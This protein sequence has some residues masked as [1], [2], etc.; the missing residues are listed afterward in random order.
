MMWLNEVAKSPP[1]TLGLVKIKINH[2]TFK[3]IH[4]WPSN[5]FGSGSGPTCQSCPLS[6]SF[7]LLSFLH[8]FRS[9]DPHQICKTNCCEGKILHADFYD[10]FVVRKKLCRRSRTE[11]HSP[12]PA[13]LA[14]YSSLHC[15]CA[16]PTLRRSSCLGLECRR[17]WSGRV[18]KKP[19]LWWGEVVEKTQN[20]EEK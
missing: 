13:T 14:P 12:Q 15:A 20:G 5:H 9:L 17:F 2:P 8:W 11:P 4:N 16:L 3:T 19:A 1:P 10:R 18:E 7:P 6:L